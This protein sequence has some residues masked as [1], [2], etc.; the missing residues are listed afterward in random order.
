[1]AGFG[2]HGTKPYGSLNKGK[3]LWIQYL[4]VAQVISST[5]KE[6]IKLLSGI[7]SPLC[8]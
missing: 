8:Y 5:F 3:F 2:E 1:M 7:L 6:D 4:P